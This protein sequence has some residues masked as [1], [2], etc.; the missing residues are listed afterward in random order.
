M[1]C[2]RK[3]LRAAALF[4][5]GACA[6]LAHGGVVFHEFNDGEFDDGDWVHVMETVNG[7]SATL[8]RPA[9]DG[10]PDAYRRLVLNTAIAP[11]GQ[12]SIVFSVNLLSGFSHDPGADGDVLLIEYSEDYRR[13]AGSTVGQMF[14]VAV[15]Q[16]G[17][18][19]V[20]AGAFTGGPGSWT[21][22]AMTAFDASDFARIDT[23]NLVTGLDLL[24]TPD[25]TAT[26]GTLEFGFFRAAQTNVGGFAVTTTQGID[27][28]HLR[29]TTLI[30]AP[31]SATL[32]TF[33]GVLFLSRGR[34]VKQTA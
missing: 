23:T 7:G 17:D 15:R 14:G 29:V 12:R 9:T 26:G 13:F 25:F 20:T 21:T 22:R 11:G 30:P 19:F 1:G 27:N 5:G 33:A 31:G 4:I 3:L 28:W 6:S 24:S 32:A 2:Q 10:N 34:R 16:G 18:V 8:T